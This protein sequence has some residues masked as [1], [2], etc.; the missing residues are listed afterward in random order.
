MSA[1]TCPHCTVP[2]KTGKP[3]CVQCGKYVDMS[4]VLLAD[5]C[6]LS[7]AHGSTV[8]TDGPVILMTFGSLKEGAEQTSATIAIRASDVARFRSALLDRLLEAT[9]KESDRT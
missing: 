9:E 5:E 1:T 8:G 4:T 3:F 6:E 2:T 7:I